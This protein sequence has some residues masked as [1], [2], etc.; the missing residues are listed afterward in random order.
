VQPVERCRSLAAAPALGCHAQKE[1]SA[2]QLSI[3]C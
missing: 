2:I 3:A 1:I